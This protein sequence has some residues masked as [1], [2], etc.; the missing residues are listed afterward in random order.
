[1]NSKRILNYIL[2][3]L[4]KLFL[5]AMAIIIIGCG[6]PMKS[7][8][9]EKSQLNSFVFFKLTPV[10]NALQNRIWLEKFSITFNGTPKQISPKNM[11]LQTELTEY[12]LSIAAM[13][14]EGIPLAQAQWNE[15]TGELLS[16]N[17]IDKKFNPKQVLQDLQ[18]VNWPIQELRKTMFKGFTVDEKIAN[19]VRI[20]NFYHNNKI[21]IKIKEIAIKVNFEQIKLGYQISIIRLEDKSLE[22]NQL[23]NSALDETK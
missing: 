13:S 14:F 2:L 3:L 19:G 17:S 8:L 22:N 1:M 7:V 11:L 4:R 23:T 12:G 16:D 21:I 6:S 5:L 18:S 9:Q 20:R 10:P 15:K